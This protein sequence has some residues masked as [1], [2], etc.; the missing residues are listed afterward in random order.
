MLTEILVPLPPDMQTKLTLVMEIRDNIEIV[1]TSEYQNLLKHR[2]KVLQTAL[3]QLTQP[4][5]GARGQA[6]RRAQAS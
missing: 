5:V 4:Q 2:C 6:V 3:L 1:H